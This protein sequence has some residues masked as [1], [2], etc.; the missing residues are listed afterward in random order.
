MYGYTYV[1]DHESLLWLYID[2]VY[3]SIMYINSHV[4]VYVHVYLCI[5]IFMYIY[6]HKYR[7]I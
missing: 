2:Y 1:Y 3:D 7:F 5:F 4:Y 6:I